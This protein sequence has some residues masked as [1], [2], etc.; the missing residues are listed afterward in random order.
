MS[1]ERLGPLADVLDH[2]DELIDGVPL[3]AG[4]LDELPSLLHDRSALGRPG[5][6]NSATAPKLEQALVL[7]Q[8]QRAQDGIRVHTENGRKVAGRRKPFTGLRLAVRYRTTYLGGDLEVKVGV[9]ILVHLDSNQ[10][11]SDTSS[12]M[13][14]L[15]G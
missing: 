12:L 8:P 13:N 2:L 9:V 5:N 11:T 6:R 10:C 7:Q 15:P 14:R 1:L 4:E 3:P